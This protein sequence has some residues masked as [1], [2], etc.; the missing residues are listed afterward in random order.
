METGASSRALRFRLPGLWNGEHDRD[1][2]RDHHQ[3]VEGQRDESRLADRDVVLTAG[4]GDHA[5][6]HWT[7]SSLA[8]SAVKIAAEIATPNDAPS[9]DA[10]L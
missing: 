10:I 5:L 3:Q 7:E 1:D 4:E 9:D 6:S 2:R 8:L